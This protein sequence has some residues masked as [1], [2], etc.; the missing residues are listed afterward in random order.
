[1]AATAYGAA[2]TVDVLKNDL[3]V[4]VTMDPSSLAIV[5]AP[6]NGTAEVNAST[7]EVSYTPNASF[8]GGD[9]FNYS[10]ADTTGGV[11]NAA[12]VVINVAAPSA[13]APGTAPPPATPPPA[14]GGS[15]GGG[16]GL[17]WTTLMVLA[18]AAAMRQR[19]RR[20]R[21]DAR[22]GAPSLLCMCNGLR[23][24]ARAVA[25]WFLPSRA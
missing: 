4:D 20:A 14:S 13:D 15:G 16:G 12:W 6:Q 17:D 3:V 24:G 23:P 19:S 11:S 5:T 8:S 9:R 7:G 25:F 21:R 18:A 10:V 2:V 22:G 1:M